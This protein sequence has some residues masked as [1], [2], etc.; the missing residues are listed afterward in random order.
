M[1]NKLLFIILTVLLLNIY[2]WPKEEKAENQFFTYPEKF[3]V[4]LRGEVVFPGNYTFYE[5]TALIDV[6]NYAGGLTK[7]ANIN[8]INLNE[9]ISKTAIINIERIE[10]KLPDELSGLININTATFGELVKVD[11][12]TDNRAANIILY[13]EQ[14]GLFRNLEELL[15]VK[16][17]GEAT[18]EKIKNNLTV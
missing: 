15:N 4:S 1:K 7:D 16:H 5:P 10:T 9:E 14:N 3:T 18:F 17:I 11:G 8:I 12:I 13:R 6:I 2:F